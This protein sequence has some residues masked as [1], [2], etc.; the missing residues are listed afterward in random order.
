MITPQ[1]IPLPHFS[2]YELVTLFWDGSLYNTRVVRRWLDLD[3]GDGAWWYEV[4]G[5]DRK[6]PPSALAPRD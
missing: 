2:Q 5:F 3:D 1:S 4:Q 6:F